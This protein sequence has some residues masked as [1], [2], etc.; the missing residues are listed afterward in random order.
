MAP[1]P[2]ATDGSIMASV[3][4]GSIESRE[5]TASRV[6]NALNAARQPVRLAA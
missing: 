3:N 1:S 2:F 4:G 5:R 6:V